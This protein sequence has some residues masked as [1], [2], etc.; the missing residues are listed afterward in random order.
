MEQQKKN[1]TCRK[2]TCCGKTPIYSYCSVPSCGR[3]QCWYIPSQ[4]YRYG[5]VTYKGTLKSTK[6][7]YSCRD[8]KRDVREITYCTG[9][10]FKNIVEPYKSFSIKKNEVR[11]TDAC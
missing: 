5:D 10:R 7:Y 8:G 9:V 11:Y 4:Y 1:K 2:V 3:A 6:I